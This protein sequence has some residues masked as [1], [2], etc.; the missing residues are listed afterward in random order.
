MSSPASIFEI[1]SNQMQGQQRLRQGQQQIGQH[2]QQMD[3]EKQQEFRR[4]QQQDLENHEHM[5]SIGALPIINGMVQDTEQ[6]P[7][8]TAQPA[9]GTP[10]SPAAAQP[11]TASGGLVIHRPPNGPKAGWTTAEG[12]KAQYELPSADSQRFR[13]MMALRAENVRRQAQSEALG[14]TAGQEQAQQ[15]FRNGFGM[16]LTPDQEDQYGVPP[17]QKWLPSEVANLATRYNLVR[18]AETRNEG[19]ESRTRMRIDAQKQLLDLKDQFADEQNH[20]KLD[21]QDRWAKARAAIA[22]NTQNALNSRAQLN[23]LDRSQREH[24]QLLDNTYRETQKQLGAQALL[25][26]N[27]TPDG[28]EV[29]DPFSGRKFTMNYAQRLRMKNAIGQSSQQVNSWTQR[30][31]DIEQRFKLPG[32]TPPAAAPAPG[33][34]AARGS[35]APPAPA[36]GGA[37]NPQASSTAPKKKVGDVVTLRNGKMM[38]ITGIRPDG[39]YEGDPARQ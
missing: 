2:Q 28:S 29:A 13:Q 34:S 9:V 33:G 7:P 24:G 32:A 20:R 21:Y 12:E 8:L 10:G 26:P 38:R 19:A 35:A 4:Q 36:P 25:D 27:M 3:L 37:P 14:R 31:A 39:T 5:M 23:L 22:G 30:A 18:G 6:M 11:V 16:K 1:L 15:E 17:G